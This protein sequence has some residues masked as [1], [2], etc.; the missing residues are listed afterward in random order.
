MVGSGPGRARTD[1]ELLRV[2]Q[3][4]LRWFGF[5][6]MFSYGLG[7]NKIGQGMAMIG[8]GWVGAGQEWLGSVLVWQVLVRVG[9]IQSYRVRSWSV[10]SWF[11]VGKFRD[12][13]DSWFLSVCC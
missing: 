3:F 10:M 13:R 2:A 6:V 4:G 1:S 11:G 8:L 7:N 5:L 12:I 9:R